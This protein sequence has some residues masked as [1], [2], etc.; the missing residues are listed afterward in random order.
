MGQGHQACGH[1]AGVSHRPIFH[2]L[3]FRES[4]GHVCKGSM[5]G[6]KATSAVRNFFFELVTPA[7]PKAYLRNR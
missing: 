6:P 3:L 7:P 4:G 1:Q 2:R 5:N